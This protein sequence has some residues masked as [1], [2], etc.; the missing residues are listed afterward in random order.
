MASPDLAYRVYAHFSSHDAPTDSEAH[1]SPPSIHTN[2]RAS[3]V[4]RYSVSDSRQDS[5]PSYAAATSGPLPSYHPYP[6]P[7]RD[8]A[9][10]FERPTTI[11][12]LPAQLGTSADNFSLSI[13]AASNRPF[14]FSTR[15]SVPPPPSSE[16]RPL[17]QPDRDFHIT[18]NSINHPVTPPRSSSSSSSLRRVGADA[19]KI[20]AHP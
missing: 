8:N 3:R 7:S 11:H 2:E 20:R 19:R 16:R 5:P 12:A 10:P 4:P 1:I 15:I 17:L 18:Y 6:R 13:S 9:R 14:S